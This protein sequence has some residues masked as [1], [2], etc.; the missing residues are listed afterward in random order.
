MS[1]VTL[2]FSAIVAS[3][4]LDGKLARRF[5]VC[6]ASGAV[7]DVIFRYRSDNAEG[8]P[9]LDT[10]RYTR[11]FPCISD[12]FRFEKSTRAESVRTILF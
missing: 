2:L 3:D 7:L 4:I 11:K 12:D 9:I 8:F 10:C 5:S 6:T 1:A